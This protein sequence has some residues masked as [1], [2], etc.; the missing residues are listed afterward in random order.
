MLEGNPLGA[1]VD[2]REDLLRALVVRDWWDLNVDPPRVRSFAFKVS[3]PFSVNVASMIGLE[4]AVR[5]MVEVLHCP[6]GGIVSFNCG[7][8]RN[9]G[10]DARDELDPHYHDNKAHANVYYWG[11]SSRRKR[12]AKA[13]AEMCV[14][15]HRPRFDR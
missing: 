5:H 10:F 15:V 13:L 4:G 7:E 8:A 6:D 2:P 9:V 1:Q 12:D 14:T 11:S 3:T